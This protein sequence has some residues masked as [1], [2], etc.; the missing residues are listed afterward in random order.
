[1]AKSETKAPRQS[2]EGPKELPLTEK[3]RRF[4][5]EYLIDLNA[6][7]AAIRAGYSQ[8]TANEQA[9]RLMKDSRVMARIA[10]GMKERAKRTEITQDRVLQELAK[11]GFSDIRKAVKWGS[12]VAVRDAETGEQTIF[13]GIAVI[14]STEIDD[15][16]AAAIAEISEGRDGLKVK[17][18]DKRAALV[19]IGRH[20]GMFKHVVEHDVQEDSPMAKLMAQI[21]GTGF[22]PKV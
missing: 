17:F 14:D 18:H 13:H 15:D 2:Q 19:D 1:M 16:T 12:E 3:A 7:Q 4:C 11:I 6:T 20:L 21:A 5:S 22:K 10:E 9:V 8:R